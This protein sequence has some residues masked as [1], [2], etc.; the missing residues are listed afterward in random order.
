MYTAVCTIDIFLVYNYYIL[1]LLD[2]SVSLLYHYFTKLK[3]KVTGGK[4]LNKV[5]SGN[6]MCVICDGLHWHQSFSIPK[7]LFIALGLQ[8]KW[9]SI[10]I[11]GDF[12]G[13]R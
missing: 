12:S 5:Q 13:H 2:V 11:E 1:L 9:L 3:Y 6:V 8:R 4:R 10:V 7:I